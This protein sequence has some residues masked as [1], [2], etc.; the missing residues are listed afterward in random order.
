MKL[1]VFMRICSS[2]AKRRRAWWRSLNRRPE[3]RPL[4]TFPAKFFAISGLR[5]L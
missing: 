1:M 3:C 4:L 2:P 5:G